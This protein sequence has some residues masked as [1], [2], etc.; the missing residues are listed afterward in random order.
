[1]TPQAIDEIRTAA[2]RT[3]ALAS[4]AEVAFD[5]VLWPAEADRQAIEC[6]AHLIG[7]T[8]EAAAAAVRV[9]D[10]HNSE[11]ADSQPLTGERAEW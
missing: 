4:A 10:K 9:A 2:A 6:I 8:H 7:A 5:A 3:V 11:L 1:M